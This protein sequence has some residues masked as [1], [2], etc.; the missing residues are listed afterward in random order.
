M[1]GLRIKRSRFPRWRIRN[2][3]DI[4]DLSQAHRKGALKSSLSGGEFQ[5]MLEVQHGRDWNVFISRRG[6]KAYRLKH[7]GRYIRRPP[8]A[9]HRLTQIGP[10]RIEYLGKDT[11]TKPF[12]R[13][14]YTSEK[15]V[16]VLVQHVP[17]P[18]R[19]SMR[20]FGLL[21]P[22]CK[23]RKWAAVFV[24][25]N[26]QQRSHPPGFLGGGSASR[27][28][29]RIRWLGASRVQVHADLTEFG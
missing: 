16:E 11:R 5:T 2:P 6:S 26:Q 29:A 20:Y 17:D 24:L 19:H 25:L 10:D 13:M 22:R 27:R 4:C 1:T 12:V 15:F 9:Q 21:S 3:T 8:I 28:S 18:A 14:E 7:D 23:A